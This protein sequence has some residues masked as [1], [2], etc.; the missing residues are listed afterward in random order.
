MT[1]ILSNSETEKSYNFGFTD[2]YRFCHNE[3]SNHEINRYATKEI[4]CMLCGTLQPVSNRCVNEKCGTEFAKYFCSFCNF[5]DDT[6]DKKI[7]HCDGCKI[8]RLG[9]RDD[10]KHCYN[11][12]GCLDASTFDKHKCLQNK[13]SDICPVCRDDLFASREPVTFFKQCGHPIHEDCYKS[14]IRSNI[15]SCPV[16]KKYL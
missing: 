14:M 10:F 4:V 9:S 15:A 1:S 5:Y 8:C 3:Q 6:P 11:C 7:F 16:C 12:N 13:L 2:D